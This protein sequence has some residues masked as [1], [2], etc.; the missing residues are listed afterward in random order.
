[1]KQPNNTKYSV[2]LYM[3]LSRDDENYGDSVSI[4]TQRTILR[5]YANDHNLYVI[6]EY[7]DDGW[8]GTNFERPSFQRMMSD[9]D[10]GRVNCIITK[11]LSRFGREHVMMD[12]YLEFVFPEKQIRYIAVAENEDTEKGLSDFV[13]F[14]NLFNEWFAKDTSRKV[15]TALHAKFAS[16]QKICTYAPLGY[17]KHPEIKNSIVVD[18]ETSWIIE[19]IFDL[20]VHGY[21]AAKITKT[22]I[23]EKVPTAG[24][25]NYKRYGTF[26]NIYA[27]A[28]EEKSYAWTI[29]QV[30]SILK[31]ETYIGNSIHN[32]QT[33]ISYKNKKK[34]RKPQEEWFRVENTHEGI[35][36][37]DVF[38]QVQGQIANRRRK[39]KDATTQIFAGLV[40]CADCG[41]SMSY[42]TNKTR[43]APYSYYNCTNYRQLGKSGGHCTAHYIRYDTLYAYVLSRLQY[44]IEQANISEEKLL[45]RLLKSGDSERDKAFKKQTAELTKAEKRKAEVDKLFV[46]MYE[47]WTAERITGYNF[48]ML[49]QKYQAEQQELIE[50]IDKLKTELS[51]ERENADGAEKWIC[52]IKQ[53]SHPTELTA[54]LLNALIEKIVIHEA[55]KGS[56]GTREQE[57][58]IFYRFVGKID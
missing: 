30:K 36:S 25:L 42:A 33:N 5:Q 29:A 55:T 1:M 10:A 15:K 31:D 2:A 54:E 14:K 46:K 21:G 20:A 7:V 6:D 47:D 58:E 50:K 53:Y 13:P 57:I 45:K 27:D 24:Y 38:E 28:P 18:S 16:G 40:K 12:Y 19:K 43:K 22:L 49:S 11:D 51:S 32:K 52:L 17:V 37:K 23:S 3:R 35:I 56:D 39:M 34:V 26:A 9:V 41:W 44:W 8:S 48:S 4:E